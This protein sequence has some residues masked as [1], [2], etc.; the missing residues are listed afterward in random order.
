MGRVV[1]VDYGKKRCGIAWTDVLQLSV[2]P[3]PW[4][5]PDKLEDYLADLISNDDVQLVLL[6]KSKHVDGTD[7]TIQK[8]IDRF[9]ERLKKRVPS[10]QI[11]F[12][13]EYKSSKEAAQY[14]R[15]TGVGKKKRSEKGALDSIAAGIILERYLRDTGRW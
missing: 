1:A 10:L 8:D 3:Q 6:T 9:A 7:N 13:E 2:N 11:D 4:I 12:A 14:L 5:T 15:D